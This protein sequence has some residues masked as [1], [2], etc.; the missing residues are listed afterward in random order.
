MELGKR[1]IRSSGRGSGSIEITLPSSLKA[2]GGVTCLVSWEA[3]AGDAPRIVL[4]PSLEP[5]LLAVG[6][7]QQVLA[8]TLQLRAARLPPAA[9]E[10]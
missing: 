8:S 3:G 7:L 9:K 1:S 2:F 4:T 10:L 5:G 6:R